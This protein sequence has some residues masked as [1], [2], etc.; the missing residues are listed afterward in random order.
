[1]LDLFVLSL[2]NKKLLTASFGP[3][4][5]LDLKDSEVK[6]DLPLNSVSGNEQYTHRSLK[7]PMG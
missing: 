3:G 7:E 4:T 2:K 1:M 6:I 5:M